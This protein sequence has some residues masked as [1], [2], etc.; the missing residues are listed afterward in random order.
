MPRSRTRRAK[1]VSHRQA[2][3]LLRTFRPAAAAFVLHL[4][5]CKTCSSLAARFLARQ[6]MIAGL[7][8]LER[9]FISQMPRWNFLSLLA[10]MPAAPQR[11]LSKTELHE[12]LTSLHPDQRTNFQHLLECERCRIA[13]GRTLSPQGLPSSRTASTSLVFAMAQDQETLQ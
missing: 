7:S 11:D 3:S 8:P 2:L 5:R 10:G 9:D 1:K 6:E 13:A 12:F 4:T